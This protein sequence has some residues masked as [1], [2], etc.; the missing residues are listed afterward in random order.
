MPSP[1]IS[2]VIPVLN[3]G[4]H[5]QRTV[6]AIQATLPE[7]SEIIIVDDGSTD[8]CTDFIQKE[9][10]QSV[11]RL[12]T[13]NRGVAGARNFGALQARGD[14]IA[15]A[16]AHITPAERWWP[17]LV[18][19]LD[20]PKAGAVGCTITAMGKEEQ[21]GYG[22]APT[23]SD[24]RTRWLRRQGRS[25]Y[26]VPALC[27][28]F[29]LLPR[30]VFAAIGGFDEGLIRWGSTDLE[31]SL[32]LWLLGYQLW[33]DPQVEVAH[34][35]RSSRPYSVSWQ[36]VLHNRLRVA[37]A[38]FNQQRI[39]RIVARLKEHYQFDAALALTVE[40][41]VWEQRRIWA[42]QRS[43]DDNWYFDHFGLIC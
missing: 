15:F 36:Q 17:S 31:F 43:F 42:A 10:K 16:D 29:V 23:G 4:T 3:E 41:N 12:L 28:C 5:L 38:H 21:K 26:V 27:T 32:R 6:Q 2:V 25:P 33:L 39:T 18:K 22:L 40:S 11:R 30:R 13:K 34:L 7:S 8:G 35:F 37:F 9:A 24:L 14:Y 19:I 20:K 1:K